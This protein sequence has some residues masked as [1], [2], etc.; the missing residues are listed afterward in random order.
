[1][2]CN[3]LSIG[4]RED[5]VGVDYRF[6]APAGHVSC[7]ADDLERFVE[8][9]VVVFL[10]ALIVERY[11]G[12]LDSAYDGHQPHLETDL[13]AK[14]RGRLEDVGIVRQPAQ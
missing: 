12:F 3:G 1:M 2:A 11:C 4:P 14:P 13:A 9:D 8:C 6:T 5:G 10:V 7:Q